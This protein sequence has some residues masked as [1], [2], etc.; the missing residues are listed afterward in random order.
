MIISPPANVVQLARA[1]PM[2]QHFDVDALS[3]MLQCETV[4]SRVLPPTVVNLDCWFVG[5][6]YF[7]L[8]RGL[9]GR[10]QR[11][12]LLLSNVPASC[13]TVIKSYPCD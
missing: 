3:S 13:Y 6:Q 8:V 10:C 9:S 1:F 12:R 11:L 7:P 2:L 4:F 5:Q